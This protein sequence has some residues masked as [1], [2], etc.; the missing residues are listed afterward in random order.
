M[1]IEM[2]DKIDLLQFSINYI[3]DRIGRIDNKANILIAIQTGTF[4][5]LTWLIEKIFIQKTIYVDEAYLLITINAMLSATIICLLLQAIRPSNFFFGLYTSE[6]NDSF[7]QNFIWFGTKGSKNGDVEKNIKDKIMDFEDNQ[8]VEEYSHALR[9]VQLL[10][11]R[12]YSPYRIAT[13]I[14]KYQV[15][16]LF[17]L[18]LVALFKQVLR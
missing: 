13:T 12:K 1:E 6:N 3:E 9:K 17:L 8:F 2:N 10:A 15:F 11:R 4:A 5:A 16:C 14:I 7:Q 18:C